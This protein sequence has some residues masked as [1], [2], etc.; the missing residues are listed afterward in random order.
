[1]ITY[2]F[3]NIFL[4]PYVHCLT[5]VLFKPIIT[6]KFPNAC[7]L[8]LLAICRGLIGSQWERT[9]IFRGSCRGRQNRVSHSSSKDMAVEKRVAEVKPR[10]CGRMQGTRTGGDKRMISSACRTL[11]VDYRASICTTLI[12]RKAQRFFNTKA[13]NSHKPNS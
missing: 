1:M 12:I 11:A 7:L 9:H 13:Q 3:A 4:F 6:A 2:F 8:E 10:D 5:C